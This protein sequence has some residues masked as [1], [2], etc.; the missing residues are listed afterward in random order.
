VPPEYQDLL[1]DPQTS[2]GFLV[3]LAPAHADS[4]LAAFARHGV[5]AR[6]VGRVLEKTS[7]LI[8]VL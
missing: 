6:R 1:F 2:G 8:S 7:P 3:A 4:A 5:P